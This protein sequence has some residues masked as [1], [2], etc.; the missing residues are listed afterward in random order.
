MAFYTVQLAGDLN[1]IH[2][3]NAFPDLELS[4]K[5]SP[6][7]ICI[8]AEMR[9]HVKAGDLDLNLLEKNI[10]MWDYD[11]IIWISEF[12]PAGHPITALLHQQLIK[13]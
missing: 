2:Q 12:V 7:S 9:K 1:L 10:H 11:H 5:D 6:K 8:K 4:E 3:L 13:S